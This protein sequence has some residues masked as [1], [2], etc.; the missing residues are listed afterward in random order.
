MKPRR[1]ALRRLLLDEGRRLNRA[2]LVCLPAQLRLARRVELALAIKDRVPVR[3]L[4]RLLALLLLLLVLVDL[5]PL[6]LAVLIRALLVGM[7]CPRVAELP[8]HRAEGLA[9]LVEGVVRVMLG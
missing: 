4:K 5:K 3:L 7:C 9:R 2:H 1:L 8:A 6:C